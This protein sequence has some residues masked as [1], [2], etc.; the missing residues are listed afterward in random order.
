MRNNKAGCSKIVDGCTDEN[1]ISQVFA[2]KYKHLYNSV[3]Y[4]TS[5]LRDI[6]DDIEISLSNGSVDRHF[7]ISCDE[8]HAAVIKLKPHKGDGNSGLC[9]DYFIHAGRDLSVHIAILFTAIVLHGTV[10]SDFLI[11]TII[12]IP[13][14]RHSSS[15]NSDNF[16]GIALSSVYCKLL[17]HVILCK[18]QDKLISSELQFGFKQKSS[19]RPT[20]VLWF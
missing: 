18:Y 5:E 4:E 10:P 19:T 11:S 16:R 2:A 17:D 6:L 12:P 15:A 13:K 9:S 7:I 1:S 20:M 14:N 3:P 8:I